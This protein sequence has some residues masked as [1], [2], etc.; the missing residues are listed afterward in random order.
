MWLLLLGLGAARLGLGLGPGFVL[1]RRRHPNGER[2]GGLVI[3]Q[4]ITMLCD[5]QGW[6]LHRAVLSFE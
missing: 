2:P 4:A 5:P 3:A 1:W 6:R